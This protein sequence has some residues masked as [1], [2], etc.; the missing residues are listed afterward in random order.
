MEPGRDWPHCGGRNRGLNRALFA[1]LALFVLVGL[2]LFAP[3][4]DYPFHYDDRHSI[5]HNKHLRSL[6]N[7]PAFFTDPGTFS[8]ERVGTMFRPLLLVSYA[9]NYALHETR[10]TGYRLVNL[11]LHAL[12]ATL[13]FALV[14]RSGHHREAW[15][16]GWLF[17]LHP[18][19]REP[20]HYISSR[21]DLLVSFFYLLAVV[22][23]TARPGAGLAAYAAG[24][25]SKSVAITLPVALGLWIWLR[26]GAARL[27]NR[28]FAGLLLLSGLYLAT[29]LAN[30]FLT[31]SLAKAPRPFDLQLWTQCKALV[32]YL[33]LFCMPRALSVEHPFAVA[34][35]PFDPAVVLSG[36]LLASLGWLVYVGRRRVEALACAFFVLALAP[37]SLMPLNI[38]VSE[39]RMYLA[40]AGLAAIAVWAWG[41]MVR[42]RGRAGWV[43]GVALCGVLAL[44]G[45]Q[46]HPVWS[47]DI[48]LWED[49]VAKGPE[50]F[51]ARANLGL[52]YAKEQRWREAIAQLEKVLQIKPDYAD[53]WVELGNIR[54]EL[55][56]LDRA[57]AD[58]RRALEFNPALEGVYYN[59]GNIAMHRGN[60]VAASEFYRETLK[61]NPEFTNAYNNLGQAL[62]KAGEI[63]RALPHYQ[64]AVNQDPDFGGAW[65]NL[66]GV[67]EKLG[68][69][70]AAIAAYE[71][72]QNLLSREPEFQAYAD[73]AR[74]A[75]E[76]LGGLDQQ[77]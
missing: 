10:P 71:R 16:L 5:E 21:S 1:P 11:L 20:V 76:R 28:F 29:I 6:G 30:R 14:A 15:A 22:L 55:G 67:R 41:R 47:S 40:S 23:F 56:A 77:N 72:A 19:H 27:R 73:Q 13:L 44:L 60:L 4:L 51:R 43:V 64:E 53:A 57:E 48:A 54:H 70:P 17:L 42:R 75:L 49:A 8:S 37:A 12:C 25:L 63:E 52:A 66:A 36:L 62:E 2:G 46:R 7:I 26:E 9:L 32:Y 50:M 18:L 65:Y 45:W 74:R 59:L 38:L 39:R 68:Q 3:A 34:Q 35:S 58:Y 61:R 33:W 31:S 69:I 24:L